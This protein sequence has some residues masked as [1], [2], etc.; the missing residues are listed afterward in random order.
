M[1]NENRISF[2]N[3]NFA[4]VLDQ[5]NYNL[6]P[7]DIVAGTIFNQEKEG[8]LVDIGTTIAGYLPNSEISLKNIK[9][10]NKKI[11]TLIN[12]TREFF[13]LAKNHKSQQLLLS[14]KR[15]SYIR[16]WQRIKQLEQEDTIIKIPINNI[17][18]GGIVVYLEGLTGFIPNSHM[19]NQ[20][21]QILKINTNIECQILLVNEKKNQIILSNKRAILTRN[22]HQIKLG[23]IIDGKI[24]QIKEYGLLINIHGMHALLHISEISNEHINNIYSMFKI[25]QT[26][27]AKIIHLDFQ[28]G[29][30]S[31]STRNIV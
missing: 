2:S 20:K 8:L 27:R 3:K 17:N 7:G 10:N 12:Q 19:V 31:M 21:N 26:I 23:A 6:N 13:I 14:I 15:L 1:K 28:Q 24:I 22:Y 9:T 30:I 18:K 4:N 25:G 29:R 5:Y 11:N 16:A